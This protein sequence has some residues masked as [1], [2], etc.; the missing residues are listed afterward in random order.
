MQSAML[1]IDVL[2]A[3]AVSGIQL[4]YFLCEHTVLLG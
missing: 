4:A 1:Q 2:K 3:I